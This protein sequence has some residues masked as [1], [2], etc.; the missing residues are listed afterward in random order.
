MLCYKMAVVLAYCSKLNVGDKCIFIL[1]L[2]HVLSKNTE[3]MF[4]HRLAII[5]LKPILVLPLL[6]PSRN[7]IAPYLL[8]ILVQSCEQ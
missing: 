2:P 4:G 1:K 7:H 3:Q 5:F 8:E 6:H